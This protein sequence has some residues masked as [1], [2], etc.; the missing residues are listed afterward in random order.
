MAK[1]SKKSSSSVPKVVAAAPV[2]MGKKKTFTDADLDELDFGDMDGSQHSSDN[3]M[4]GLH[5]SDDDG[6]SGGDFD[7]QDDDEEDSDDDGAPEEETLAHGREE[8][9]ERRAQQD[10]L[11]SE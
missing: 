11:D 2:P 3:D 9:Q 6:P 8:D 5:S 7:S 1:P 10:K 4:T